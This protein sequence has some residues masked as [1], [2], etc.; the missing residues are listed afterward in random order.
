MTDLRTRFGR[1]LRLAIVGGGPESW[2]GRMHRGAADLD[3]WWQVV[4]GV[5]SSDAARSRAAGMA[6]GLAAKRSYG[7]LDE[8]LAEEKRR[9]DGADAV[10]IMTPNDAHY[11]QA[12]AALDAGFDVI[13]DKPV[14]NTFAEA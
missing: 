3:G 13:C 14:S 10:A 1:P 9:P 2:I 5:F 6:L 11:G 4:S 12:A 8:L 7:H